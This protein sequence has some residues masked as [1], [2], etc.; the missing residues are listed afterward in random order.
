M[1]KIMLVE[2]DVYIRDVT[3][4]RLQNEAFEIISASSGED[5]LSKVS[6]NKPDL[7]LMDL[8]L[9]D[10]YGLEVMSEMKKDQAL[11]QVPFIIFS[12]NDAPEIIQKVISSGA[13]DFFNKSQTDFS[14]ML[15]VINRHLQ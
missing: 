14:E 2:D 9:P 3:A 7:V 12:N 8:D 6:S 11:A 10:M 15:A 4:T 1:K 5:A 13:N